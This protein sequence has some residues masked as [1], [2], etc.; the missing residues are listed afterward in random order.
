MKINDKKHVVEVARKNPKNMFDLDGWKYNTDEAGMNHQCLS[1]QRYALPSKIE[2]ES[3]PLK[4][5]LGSAQ[6]WG[7]R[8]PW[9]FMIVMTAKRIIPP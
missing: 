9:F 6:G 2:I 5:G 8:W 3:L 7:I 1:W 4:I